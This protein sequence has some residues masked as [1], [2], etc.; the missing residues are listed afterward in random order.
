MTK[1][2]QSNPGRSPAGSPRLH[3]EVVPAVTHD[4]VVIVPGIMGS[5]LYDAVT[6]RVLW[7]LAHPQW[8][9]RAWLSRDGLAPLHLTPEEQDGTFGRVQA[10]RLLRAPA[11][12]PFLRGIEPYHKLTRAI[13]E[14]VADPA[15]IM[16][17]PYD[18]RLPV[19]VNARL[20]AAEARKHLEQWR[21]HPAH[22]A[23]RRRAVDEREGRLVFVAHSM[24]GLVT[25]AALT[26]GHDSELEADTRGVMTLG[27]PFGGSVVA[28][29]ILNSV[30]GA[31]LPLP[32]SRLAAL[33][34]T[35]PGVHDL[36]PR[37]VCLEEGSGARRLTPS[38]VGALGGDEELAKAS[39]EFFAHLSGREMPGHRSVAG[40]R[41]DT[42]QSL[43]L[44]N[45]TVRASEYC[46]R[47]HG[48]GELMRDDDG[49]ARRFQ[50]W[51]DGTV[52]RH[53]ASLRPGAIPIA[54]QHGALASG[55]AA[56]QTVV[57]FLL[58]ED[59]LGPDQ[60]D[61]GLGLTV[62]DY[63]TTG[64]PWSLRI[65]GTDDPA[66]IDCTVEAVDGGV[67]REVRPYAGD[68][69]ALSADVELP[70][71]GLYRVTVE[72]DRL[73]SPLTQ[74]LF[75]GPGDTRTPQD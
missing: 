48:N 49:V 75:A 67:R 60:A 17:F 47:S 53:S 35:M 4:A 15:A 61:E 52:H 62:P 64:S 66:G 8:L 51:G 69:D 16:P 59:D 38:D 41:Q 45:G 7:G 55:R 37:F 5:E 18:W 70:A 10:R 11:W 6:G 31:P 50:A 9:A 19:A 54:L 28:A 74:L 30:Q 65:T 44:D 13:E 23:A 63:V 46:F 57:D 72:A 1:P 32:H 68:G 56:R 73:P 40:I 22:A 36:L 12:S 58:E 71:A 3:P 20:L 34:S 39:L 21:R 29:N 27:T 33:A 42:V 43:R 14:T 2:P 24:G 26:L 25:R